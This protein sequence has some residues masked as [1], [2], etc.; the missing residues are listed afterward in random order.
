[1]TD[2]SAVYLYG[3]ARG[4]DPTAL[5]DVAGVADAPVRCVEAGGLVALVSSVRLDEYGEEALR[6]NLEN[7]A[8]LEATARAHHA[9]V[10]RAART[11]P[12]APVRIATV[13]RDDDRVAQ[14]LR[15]ESERFG[16]ALDRV[17]GRTEW[18]VKAYARAEEARAGEPD[19]SAAAVPAAAPPAETAAGGTG[20]AY[21]RRRQEQRRRREEA[22]RRLA[23][24]AQ[25]IHAELDGQAVAA[26]RHPPQDPRLSRRA[27]T[28]LL[29]M[30]YLVDDGDA[31]RFLSVAREIDRRTPGID[32]EVTGPWPPYS[33]IDVDEPSRSPGDGDR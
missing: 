26:R 8:W 23:D 33:F 19:G 5:G 15:R 4:L 2:A 30:A 29:N 25:A 24:R 1:M 7:L 16:H 10:G 32:V 12:T 20:T 13:Y 9:V 17:T 22:G 11:A 14:V 6:A 28:L 21:L 3:V 27:G 31:E 18:G